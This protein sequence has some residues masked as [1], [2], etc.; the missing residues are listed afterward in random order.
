MRALVVFGDSHGH[1][2]GWMLKPGFRHVFCAVAARGCWLLIDGRAGV[3]DIHYLTTDDF[4]LATFY[5]AKGYA[6]VE[7]VQRD[8]PL[9]VPLV[10]VNCVGLVKAALCIRSWA[11]TPWQLYRHLT[12]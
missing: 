7:T 2:L 11:V 3:P 8:E 5:R 9:R 12:R 10:T 4:D 1:P 6:V